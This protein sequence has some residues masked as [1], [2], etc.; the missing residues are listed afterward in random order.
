[1]KPLKLKD[2]KE[3]QKC[4]DGLNELYDLAIKL[5][6]KDIVDSY[7]LPLQELVDNYAEIIEYIT[8]KNG[9]YK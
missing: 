3:Y 6:K 8:E 1:M 5:E 9:D 2:Y 4:Q 7:Y